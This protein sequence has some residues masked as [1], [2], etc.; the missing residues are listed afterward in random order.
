MTVGRYTCTATQADLHWYAGRLFRV[1][2]PDTSRD[3]AESVRPHLSELQAEVLAVIARW[4]RGATSFDVRRELQDRRPNF[5]RNS[6]ARRITTLVELGLVEDSGDRRCPT[7]VPG[8]M[9]RVYRVTD[10]GREA[11][12]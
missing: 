8:A 12:R 3:A 9:S 1:D 11:V 7:G 5:E 2:D 4:H 10:A 6:I